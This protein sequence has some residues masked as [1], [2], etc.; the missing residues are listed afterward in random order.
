VTSVKDCFNLTRFPKV[1]INYRIVLIS[2]RF[3]LTAPLFG[4]P[5]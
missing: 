3:Q 1:M 2:Q 5:G 4:C